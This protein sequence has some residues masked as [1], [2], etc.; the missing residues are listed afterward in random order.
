MLR[1][2]YER[3]PGPYEREQVRPVEPPPAGLPMSRSLSLPQS[4]V[5]KGDSIT[6]RGPEMLPVL[7]REVEK[8]E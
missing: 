2:V 4:H 3:D 6:F 7:G 5:A 1:A 8:R